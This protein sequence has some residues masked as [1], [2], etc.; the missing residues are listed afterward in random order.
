SYMFVSFITWYF[1]ISLITNKRILDIDF[2]DLVY[3][4]IAE[5]KMDLIQDVSE[6]ETG[7]LRTVFNFG[8]VLVQTAGTLENF[9]LEA[10]PHPD[11]AVEIVETLIGK[12][13]GISA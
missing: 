8:D 5:T 1:N 9:N 3:K 7:V 10:V 2:Q 12:G 11:R 6:T 4:N 13:R